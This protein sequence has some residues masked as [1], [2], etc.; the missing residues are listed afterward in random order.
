MNRKIVSRHLSLLKK[1]SA[2]LLRG[3]L[4]LSL[5]S[6]NRPVMAAQGITAIWANDGEDKVTRDDLRATRGTNVKNSVWDGAKISIFGAR[7]EVVAFN[8]ILEA[9]SGGAGNVTVSFDKLTGP[10]GA[11]IAS[12]QI[13]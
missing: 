12:S 4:V 6:C 5:F 8:V 10:S 7:N 9:G 11:T 2:S 3:F 13:G 1:T